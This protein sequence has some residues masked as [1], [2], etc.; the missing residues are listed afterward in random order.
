[1]MNRLDT[2]LISQFAPYKVWI[3]GDEYRFE[4]DYGILY[5]ISFDPEEVG[6]NLKGYWLNL[7]NRSQKPSPGDI[8]IRATITCVIEE[9]FRANPDI[10]LYM[11]DTADEQQSMRS[12]LFLRWFNAYCQHQDFYSRTEKVRDGEE[13]NYIAII[14]KRSHPQLQ[15]IID[16]FDEQ[17]AMFQSNKP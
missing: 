8:K 1:M 6:V 4:T 16:I 10:L 3:E 11:C 13:E 2:N 7:Y 14:V 15:T 9:F 17:I 5:G 12:R